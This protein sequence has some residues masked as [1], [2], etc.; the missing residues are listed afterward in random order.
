MEML[1]K[2][3]FFSTATIILLKVAILKH[4]EYKRNETLWVNFGA[5][6][7][8]K[9]GAQKPSTRRGLNRCESESLAPGGG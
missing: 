7:S 1:E 8:V 3:A 6:M 5:Y 9:S 2:R 4:V